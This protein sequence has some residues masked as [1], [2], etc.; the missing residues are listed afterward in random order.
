[1]SIIV[2]RWWE[3]QAFVRWLMV[4]ENVHDLQYFSDNDDKPI[5]TYDGG[6]LC[7]YIPVCFQRSI[8][9]TF[10]HSIAA[11][12]MSHWDSHPESAVA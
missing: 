12:D 3:S 6:N 10:R 8:L 11:T 4:L 9:C 5:Q 1:M 2:Q 7:G